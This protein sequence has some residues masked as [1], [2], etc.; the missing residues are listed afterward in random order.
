MTASTDRSPSGKVRA[1][2]E[3]LAQIARTFD[4]QAEAAQ[5]VLGALQ[6]DMGTL[7]GGRWVGQGA[8]KFYAEMNRAVLPSMRRLAAALNQAAS[9]TTK[10]SRVMKQVED[11]SAA[12]F[13]L[14]GSG[15]GAPASTRSK[16]STPEFIGQV[17]NPFYPNL[18]F[19]VTKDG[20]IMVRD[21]TTGELVRH[22]AWLKQAL[23][24]AAREDA[25]DGI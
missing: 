6:K 5:K 18:E 12:L 24:K 19:L 16:G 2:Y 14:D 13:R 4:Q 1:D 10:V 11:D 3:Q 15:A 22:E 25:G 23:E 7:Q 8:A 9:T 17:P 21:I 20:Q